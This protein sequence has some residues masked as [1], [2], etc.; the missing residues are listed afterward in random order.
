MKS[1]LAAAAQDRR[2][3]GVWG[4]RRLSVLYKVFLALFS[5]RGVVH[6][7]NSKAVNQN[8]RLQTVAGGDMI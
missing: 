2:A 8:F 3:I 5:I 1:S 7:G 6:V 4:V